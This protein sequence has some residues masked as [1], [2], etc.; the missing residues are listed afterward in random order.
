MARSKLNLN[1][2]KTEA[3]IIPIPRISNSTSFLD[4]PVVEN[5]IDSW[6]FSAGS[7]VYVNLIRP[8][9]FELRRIGSVR[10]YLSVQAICCFSSALP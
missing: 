3:L 5:L 2:D 6:P 8:A 10:H 4:S 9:N 1:D 7:R